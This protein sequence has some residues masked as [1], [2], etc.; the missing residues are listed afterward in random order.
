MLA[1]LGALVLTMLFTASA[2]A[3]VITRYASP[4][5]GVGL[6]CTLDQP[7]SL[8]EAV[9]TPLSGS[10]IDVKVLP[11]TYGSAAAPILD[12]GAT[13]R[14]DSTI[15]AAD[16]GARPTVYLGGA[17][18]AYG[19]GVPLGTVS[20]IDFRIVGGGTLQYGVL[21]NAVRRSTVIG[22]AAAGACAATDISNSVCASTAAGGA[23]VVYDISG[24]GPMALPITLTNATVWGS[25]A[26]GY[27]LSM[28]SNS[29]VDMDITVRNSIIHGAGKDIRLSTD[30]VSG[31]DI[32]AVL[33]NSNFTS[34]ELV[35]AGAS[36]NSNSSN[37]NQGS[38]PLLAN[39]GAGDFH[40][41]A[42]SPTIDAGSNASAIGP[43]DASGGARLKG[44]GVDIGGFEADPPPAGP[45]PEADPKL[46]SLKV[47]KTPLLAN[48]F[49]A[50]GSLSTTTPQP[51]KY[52]RYGSKVTLETDGA[53]TIHFTIEKSVPKTKGKKKFTVK[54]LVGEVTVSVIAGKRIVY[55]T[56]RWKGKK[57]AFGTYRLVA[58]ITRK[59]DPLPLTDGKDPFVQR[60]SKFVVAKKL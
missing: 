7:C 57:L 53:A 21:A 14:D 1:L 39:P 15:E 28:S 27:G 22:S 47:L 36:I 41:L 59:G 4:S 35:G 25:G 8:K 26:D 19:V 46:L 43:A 56:G 38:A 9:E 50:A 49:S 42:G 54:S 16:V 34:T 45:S 18:T 55:L 3:A 11:G 32:D 2:S 48:P 33:S 12:L 20:D 51:A 13:G 17:T 5:A 29:F 23:G 30:G 60:K 6:P 40:E 37:E 58:T 24:G 10:T 52:K 44:S 31:A